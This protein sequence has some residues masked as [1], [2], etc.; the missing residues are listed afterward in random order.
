[1][2]TDYK[3]MPREELI[4]ELEAWAGKYEAEV[5]A[6]VSEVT[7]M[8]KAEIEKLDHTAKLERKLEL[9][10]EANATLD[11]AEEIIK[12][13]KR[14]SVW[15]PFLCAGPEYDELGDAKRKT[16]WLKEALRGK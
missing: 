9:I 2:K 13:T 15:P 1:M 4:A 5:K 8:L 11:K 3:N 14:R 10:E 16:E 6:K 7:E 12:V